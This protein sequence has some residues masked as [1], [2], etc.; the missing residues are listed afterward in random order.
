MPLTFITGPVRS[1]K[2]RFAIQLA[3]RARL[4]VTF[5]ATAG[6]YEFDAEWVERL[7]R[8]REERPPEWATVESAAMDN[9]ALCAFIA[10]QTAQTVLL[11]DALGTYLAARIDAH[12][13]AGVAES[14]LEAA[15]ERDAG[16]LEKALCECGAHAI[17]VGE[18]VGWDIVPEIAS[19]RMF[20]D[21]LGRLQRRVATSADVAYLVVTGFALD[22]ATLGT[23][24]D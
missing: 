10:S 22:L 23:R 15:V 12:L 13:H 11:I 9:A 6:T 2:S 8:H 4:P 24:I 7:R 18:Q 5:V 17:V 20:R 1:G 3:H 16:A 19:A 21:I 14:E